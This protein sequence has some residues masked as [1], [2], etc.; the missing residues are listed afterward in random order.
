M[1]TA[2]YD[3]GTLPAT[4]GTVLTVQLNNDPVLT[5]DV[6]PGATGPHHVQIQLPLKRG[7]NELRVTTSVFGGQNPTS[8]ALHIK[9][10]D[11]TVLDEAWETTE[12]VANIDEAWKLV[13]A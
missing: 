11:V 10:P 4:G 9:T 1:A 2:V 5:I 7:T 12:Q 6:P 3:V 8:A 13:Y